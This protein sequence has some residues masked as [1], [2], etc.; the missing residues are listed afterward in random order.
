MKTRHRSFEGR[1]AALTAATLTLAA[2]DV[3]WAGSVSTNE[4][5]LV[6]LTHPEPYNPDI[7]NI[8][9]DAGNNGA[10]A[11]F[12]NDFTTTGGRWLVQKKPCWVAYEFE[13]PTVINAYG[14]W[15]SRIDYSPAARAPK[16]FQFLASNDGVS[17]T[18]LDQQTGETGWVLAEMRLYRFANATS[19]TMY[20]LNVSA[21]NGDS[22]VQIHELEFYNI[23]TEG[24]LNVGGAPD[25][26]GTA[27][28]AYGSLTGAWGETIPMSVS[29]SWMAAD[30]S[31]LATCTGWIAYTNAGSGTAWIPFD[32]GGGSSVSFACP[33]APTKFEWQFVV[34]NLITAVAS[35]EGSIT[36]AGRYEASDTATLT[37]IPATGYEFFRWTGD[38]PSALIGDNPLALAA[39]QPRTVAAVFRPVGADAVQYVSP[40]GSD[41]ANGYFP[42]TA[43]KTIAAAVQV[44][45]HY[46]EAGGTVRVADGIYP[47][48]S[49][50]TVSNPIRILGESDDPSRVMV[51]N[52]TGSSFAVQERRVF[53]LANSAAL[54]SGLTIA[55]GEAYNRTGGNVNIAAAGGTVSNC[56]I[57]AGWARDNGQ[58]GGLWADGGLVTH[59][60]FRGNATGSGSVNWSFNRAGVFYAGGS[61]R[62]ENCLIETSRYSA[63]AHL[64]KVSGSAVMRNCTIVN[65]AL[66]SSSTAY[67]GVHSIYADSTSATIQNVVI[68]DV[69]NALGDA[70]GPRGS[71]TNIMMRCATDTAAPINADCV[72]GTVH[73]FFRNYAAGDYGPRGPLVD[74]GTPVPNPPATDLAGN[75][76]VQGARIDIGCYEAPPHGTLAIIR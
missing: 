75:A 64:T 26:Y 37:A 27:D 61:A 17:W 21:N 62:I 49:P 72:V 70:V 46:E 4:L 69:T 1:L 48:S 28:P 65:S 36:G 74:A 56:V 9:G 29:S 53:L 23:V 12:D 68:A 60:I 5:T 66:T 30:E 32:Q 25:A 41:D 39:S 16:D 34:S 40:S 24:V 52:T 33:E 57:V 10:G 14:I 47:V 63:E 51:S 76:R 7:V 20:K 45:N 55:K 3:T 42:E 73:T 58:A 35:A 18:T 8:T 71:G 50:I 38:V 15:N 2:A 6:D 11:A 43:K 54:L 22:Y 59:C 67:G 44:L 13:T 31:V 19:Y